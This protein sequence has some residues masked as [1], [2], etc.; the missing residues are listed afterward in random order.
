MRTR[1]RPFVLRVGG[2]DAAEV[3]LDDTSIVVGSGQK[4]MTLRRVEVEVRARVA[5][6]RSSPWCPSCGCR[7]A[8]GR[9]AS[10][11]SR[12]AARR[13]PHRPRPPRPRADR[14]EPVVDH[15]AA[16]LRGHPPAAPGSAREG[17]GNAARGGPRGAARHACGHQTAACGT[18]CCSRTSF[19]PGRPTY[20]A[21]LGWLGGVFGEVRDLDVQLEGLRADVGVERDLGRGPRPGRACPARGSGCRCSSAT[22]G[23]RGPTCCGR[24]IRCA[25][26]AWP[27]ASRPWSGRARCG[28]RSPG[29][30][31]PRSVC[32]SS[33]SSVTTRSRKQRSAPAGRAGW[34]TSTAC[35][36]AASVC[37]THSS[38]APSSTRVPP[39]DS[40]GS[41]P[42]SRTSSGDAGPRGGGDPAGGAGRR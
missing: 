6:S 17:T 34:R 36:F 27:R 23:R 24:S 21:E 9:P 12:R 19:R 18:R 8:C 1:R 10:R 3:A 39:P 33:S 32:R 41:W 5:G 37:A 16:R 42:G 14:R 31:P 38:S 40:C 22:V 7:A 30:R 2:V 4:P 15:G 35:G 13:R 26:I 20:R 11:S 29:T 28:G 25:G